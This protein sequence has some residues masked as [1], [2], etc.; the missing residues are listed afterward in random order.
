MMLSKMFS[1]SKM[2]KIERL[3]IDQFDTKL[4]NQ[5]F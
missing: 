4:K 1:I 2:W 5:R 3:Y